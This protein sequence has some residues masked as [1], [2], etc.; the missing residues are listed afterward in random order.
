[1]EL[2]LINKDIGY[3]EYL[4][5]K[6]I[7]IGI[8]S[9]ELKIEISN[10]LLSSD[11]SY[12]SNIKI[13][14]ALLAIITDKDNEFYL[15]VKKNELYITKFINKVSKGSVELE[16]T[17]Y[18][19]RYQLQKSK[20]NYVLVDTIGDTRFI[21]NSRLFENTH[22]KIND[23][24][25]RLLGEKNIY[26]K[27]RHT[28]Y[29]SFV[30]YTITNDT[31]SLKS[32][33]HT[34]FNNNSFS[35]NFRSA[36]QLILETIS[37]N[38]KVKISDIK[39][40]G[41]V[42]LKEEFTDDIIFPAFIRVAKRIYTIIKTEE[43][44]LYIK[45]KPKTEL[46]LKHSEY[47]IV[48]KLKNVVIKGT[49]QFNE[50]PEP[51][52]IVTHRGKVISNI[53][54]AKSGNF[55]A[56][57]PKE[58][59]YNLPDIHTTL[60]LAKDYE[61]I[62][63]LKRY[64]KDGILSKKIVYSTST[65]NDRVLLTRLNLANNISFTVLPRMP[66][67]ELSGRIKVEIAYVI[68][69]IFRVFYSKKIN[70]YFEKESSKIGESGSFIFEEVMRKPEISKNNYFVLDKMSP[71]YKKFKNKWGKFVIKR[72]SFKNYLYI[73]LSSSF[74]SS[75][76]SSHVITSRLFNDKLRDKIKKTPLYFL[77]HGIMFAKPVENPMAKSF[78]KENMTVNIAKN[79]ISSDLEAKEFYKMGYSDNDLMKTGL[80][81]LD[82]A[83]LN[84]DASKI[85]FMPT[86]R[87]WEEVDI[88]NGNI[89]NTTYFESL[90]NIIKAFE[91]ANLLHLLQITPHNKFSDFVEEK[92]PEYKNNI[93][94]D[95]SKALKNSKIFITDYSSIIY[96]SIFRGGY[97]IFYWKDKDYLIEKYN[98]L[99]PVNEKN[100]PG[101]IAYSEKELIKIIQ[102]A[103]K[104]NFAIEE[105]NL[106]KYRRINEFYDRKN[107]QRVI[108]ILKKEN[109]F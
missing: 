1:M 53:E 57:I 21:L 95:P 56:I 50:N 8:H 91:E 75:E 38:Q 71:D 2:K 87:Y 39:N 20:Y 97:P 88:Y 89:E 107:S 36:N 30:E 51:N 43:G 32:F 17:L 83:F 4:S 46:I 80:P 82:G 45:W 90:M 3:I 92:L 5:H 62:M 101:R 72:F 35:I 29:T 86:W 76:L 99:P 79:V 25:T 19:S 103:I 68:S 31:I 52:Q 108:D 15:H 64:N 96:D 37:T 23:Q 102:E 47:D 81:K 54:W 93:C 6:N 40:F 59:V 7:V 100:A 55:T 67:Y 77:Q 22:T 78:Y 85:T 65:F 73:F 104:K 74:I 34:N 16:F 11:E 109:L 49:I 28:S 70:L 63:P 106:I 41:E 10:D 84:Q 48:K 69:K 105:E 12:L 26:L 14:D 58:V 61:Q 94:S 24:P 33:S 9:I 44:N 18:S 98:A 60:Y 27:I 66:I 13:S 42:K